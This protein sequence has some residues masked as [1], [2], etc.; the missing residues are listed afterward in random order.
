MPF[1]VSHIAAVVPFTSR[2]FPPLPIAALAMGSMAPDVLYYI[3]PLIQLGVRTHDNEYLYTVTLL[4]ALICW[5]AWRLLAPGLH[6]VSP[7]IVRQKWQPSGWRSYPWY[8]V[9]LALILGISTHML[10]DHFTHSWG[11]GRYN[12][13]F[14]AAHYSTPFGQMAGYE[15]A[16]YALSA[17]GLL[18][19]AIVAIRAPRVL[20]ASSP[21]PVLQKFTPLIVALAAGA[22]AVLRVVLAGGT[23]LRFES[24]VFYVLTGAVLVGGCVLAVLAIGAQFLD[25]FASRDNHPLPI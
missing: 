21:V 22:G 14:I 16:Q 17:L 12:L 9:L 1:T 3:P 6:A 4:I 15:L 11:W 5:A 24:Q 23:A 19:L 18:V 8:A 2:V 7:Q 10:L 20:G 25:R 13:S